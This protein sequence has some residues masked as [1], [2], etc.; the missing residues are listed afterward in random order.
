MDQTPV[1]M[2]MRGPVALLTIDDGKV[3][4]LNDTITGS[5]LSALGAAGKQADAVVLAG[6]PGVFSAG[7]DV[8][9]LQ[10]ESEVMSD[11]F[12]QTTDLVLRLAH[13]GR[14]AAG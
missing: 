13:S 4:A 2:S 11:L 10:Q 14:P 6:R 1:S 12:H 9:I 7:L 5:L 3:N 8:A